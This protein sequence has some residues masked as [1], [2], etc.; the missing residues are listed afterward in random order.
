MD[1]TIDQSNA[2]APLASERDVTDDACSC[3]FQGSRREETRRARETHTHTHKQGA[4]CL[5]DGIGGATQQGRFYDITM[6]FGRVRFRY[7]EVSGSVDPDEQGA[8]MM[9]RAE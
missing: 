9:Y 3:S 5:T 8:H 7:L 6:R 2:T 1:K 4:V